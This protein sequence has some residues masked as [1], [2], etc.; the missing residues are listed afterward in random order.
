MWMQRS[1]LDETSASA[2]CRSDLSRLRV[3]S[4]DMT[5]K[6]LLSICPYFVLTVHN[7]KYKMRK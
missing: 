2:S 6:L 3:V 7:V 4:D 1:R 5:L